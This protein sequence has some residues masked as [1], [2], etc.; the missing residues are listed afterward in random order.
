MEETTAG[1]TPDIHKVEEGRTNDGFVDP[2]H[3]FWIRAESAAEEGI[4]EEQKVLSLGQ[5][6]FDVRMEREFGINDET[7]I[8]EGGNEG[9]GGSFILAVEN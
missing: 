7:E 9:D 2:K 5:S 3:H 8:S 1:L 6:M 4:G